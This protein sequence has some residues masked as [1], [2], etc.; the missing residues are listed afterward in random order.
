MNANEVIYRSGI[1]PTEGWDVLQVILK[2]G[3]GRIENSFVISRDAEGTIRRK[4]DVLFDWWEVVNDENDVRGFRHCFDER[5]KL[6]A[7]Q[8]LAKLE[9]ET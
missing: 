8:E 7:E 4:T 3:S 6:R 2:N 1:H 9:S 5:N